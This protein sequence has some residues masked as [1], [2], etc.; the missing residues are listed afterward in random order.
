MLRA[1]RVL[2]EPLVRGLRADAEDATDLCPRVVRRGVNG[3]HSHPVLG[4]S[5]HLLPGTE[6][7]KLRG[8]P[9]EA[10]GIREIESKIQKRRVQGVQPVF[11]VPLRW[12]EVRGGHVPRLST[13]G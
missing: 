11:W 12:E 10:I 1:S 8:R 2:R 6:F 7:G 5:N 3:G 13:K 4:H 9:A